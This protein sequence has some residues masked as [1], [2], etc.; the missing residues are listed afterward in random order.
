LAE[1]SALQHDDG[2]FLDLVY[3]A[4]LAPSLW[5]PV[6]ERLADMIGGSSG[7]LTRFSMIDGSGSVITA[8]TAPEV[9]EG[10]FAHYAAVNPLH[11]VPDAEAYLSNWTPRVLTDE[12]WM[13]KE[14]LLRSEFYNDF[15]KARDVHSIMF[16]RLAA[17]GDDIC[18]M[19]VSRPKRRGQYDRGD[20]ETAKR[21]HPH[22]IRAFDLGRKLQAGRALDAGVASVFDHSEHGL[23]ILDRSGGVQRA[24]GAAQALV[25]Q[26]R[27]LRVSGG[28]LVALRP[29]AS[30]ALE[31]LIRRASLPDAAQ[32]RGGSMALAVAEMTTPLSVTVAPISLQATPVLGEH[33]ALIVCVT[34]PS[35]GAA[36]PA[37]RLKALFGLTRAEACVAL[38]L[39]EGLGAREIAEAQGVSFHTVRA[40]VAHIFEKTAV[41]R[42]SELVGLMMRSVGLNLS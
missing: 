18:V 32:R 8:R 20:I 23:F 22:L 28:R 7:Q 4:A 3:G 40:H 38:A 34:D 16:V 27:G 25:A 21:L 13:P 1:A 39:F 19:N 9:M 31:A 41:S 15:L 29:A 26:A 12:D 14:D 5:T 17:I 35:T 10:Y 6:I 2:E 30:A 37:D 33:A 24:N 36:P 42:Q 11:K